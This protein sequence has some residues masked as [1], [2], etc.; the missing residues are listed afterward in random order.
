VVITRECTIGDETGR[1]VS[2]AVIDISAVSR[3]EDG[4]ITV[5][6]SNRVAIK[7]SFLVLVHILLLYFWT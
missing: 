6:H 5:I 4:S 3:E 7:L 1:A 2:T